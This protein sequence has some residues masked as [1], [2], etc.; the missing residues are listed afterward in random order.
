MQLEQV[1]YVLLEAVGPQMRARLRVDQ[2]GVDPHAVLVALHRAF[3]HVANAE[4][5]ADLLGVDG[6]ALEVK[7]V[8]LA[9]TK[10]LRMRDRS[11]SGCP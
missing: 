2:L 9:I 4:F 8:V 7:A 11:V 6:L 5:L 1:G 10:L 3:E